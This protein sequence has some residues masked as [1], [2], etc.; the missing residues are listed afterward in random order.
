MISQISHKLHWKAAS[1]RLYHDARGVCLPDTL[2]E[3]SFLH[4]I[5]ICNDYQSTL[6]VDT[7]PETT[8]CTKQ[9][10]RSYI[11]DKVRPQTTYSQ[12]KTFTSC[13]PL[14]SFWTNAS[15]SASN[16]V[17]QFNLQ[18]GWHLYWQDG[19]KTSKTDVKTYSQV[20][21]QMNITRHNRWLSR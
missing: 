16:F 8:Q 14:G 19:P 1:Q 17:Y 4:A 2:Q 15:L 21:D 6:T 13:Q 12:P 9:R 11:S 10:V 3:E 20:V 7:N 18:L 5:L